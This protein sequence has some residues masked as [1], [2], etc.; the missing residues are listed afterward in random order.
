MEKIEKYIFSMED[1]DKC[2]Q[3][4]ERIVIY[5][6]GNYGKK[7]IDYMFSIRIE[8]KI[9][10]IIVTEKKETDCEYR[11][12]KIQKADSF[13]AE[14]GECYVIIAVSIIYQ[15][16][17]AEIVN[18]YG[19]SYCYCTSELYLELRN[20]L[21]PDL[22]PYSGM[23]FLCPGFPKCGTS[24]LYSALRMIDGI[25]LSE[26]K[27][28]Y[29]FKWCENVENPME[30][31]IK[32]YFG[33]IRKGQTVGIIDPTYVKKAK[34]IREFFG[35]KLKLLF[36][37]RNPVESAFSGFR[38][39]VRLGMGDLDQAYESRGGKFNVD[40]FDEFLERRVHE[41]EYIDWIEPF[42]QYYAREQMKI[43]FLEELIK[44][45]KAVMNDI[46]G[47]IGVSEQYEAEKLPFKN[48]GNFV[49]ADIEGYRL[50][51]LR[52]ETF[53]SL[54]QDLLS[55]S[56]PRER[57]EKRRE[58]M[59]IK[60]KYDQAERIYKVKMTQEQR[61]KAEKCFNDSVR[62]L[63]VFVDRDLSEIWF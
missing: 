19:K 12:M 55:L 56:N 3:D 59:E 40:M 46:L 37:V 32:N 47:Y 7:L 5:G 39:A 63:E 23:D 16:E 41:Y 36:L 8:R 35:G 42:E 4:K 22:V 54:H 17:I 18:Q 25:Y 61:K 14:C 62:K 20:R 57:Y 53:Y 33:N 43:V 27:E 51:R 15:D 9:K 26:S 58:Y 1:L 48:E 24:S 21:T 10:G 31:L 2:L 38:M 52:H 29:F 28:N 13:F 49:M 34:Q 60:E 45:P 30:V 11:G 6:A 44:E 50:A